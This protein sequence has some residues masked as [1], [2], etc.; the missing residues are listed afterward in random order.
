M[1]KAI[2]IT[3]AGT[4]MG[5]LAARSLALAGHTVYASMRGIDSRNAGTAAEAR[6][7]AEEHKVDLKVLE[8]DILSAESAQAAA[9]TVRAEQGR[10]ALVH[11][12]AHLYFGITEAFTAEQIL[13]GPDIK[14]SG[15][16]GPPRPSCR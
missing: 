2:V 16:C 15:P 3:G 12:A 1:S 13:R 11:N 9:D 7:F 8:L 5:R 10:I 6:A 14:W 4:G